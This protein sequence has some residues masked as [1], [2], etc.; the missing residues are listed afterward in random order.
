M[1]G[2][3]AEYLFSPHW[4]GRA[5]L[6]FLRT[7]LANEGQSR[8]RLVLGIRYTFGSRTPKIASTPA[9]KQAKN[10]PTTSTTVLMGLEQRWA[11]ALQKADI[12]TLESILDD[13]YLDTDEMGY[14]SDKR[15][16]I[17]AL[18]SGYLKINS[19]KLSG[20]QVHSYGT[21]AI[22]TGRAMQVGSHKGQPLTDTVVFSDTFVMQNGTWKAVASHRSVS[23]NTTGAQ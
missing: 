12:A 3:G 13:T 15:E 23:P 1:L 22:V 6:D 8:L 4:S 11:D 16:L 2:G 5:N 10:E 18:R 20:M 17:A 19:I 14:Q 9:V 7:H 21:S